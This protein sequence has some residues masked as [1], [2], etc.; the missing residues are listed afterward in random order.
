ML[1]HTAGIQMAEVKNKNVQPS[2]DSLIMV[3]QSSILYPCRLENF[4]K[5]N[6]LSFF[7]SYE[8]T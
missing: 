2:S 4:W 8:S 5:L 6:F 7:L 1:K 3:E